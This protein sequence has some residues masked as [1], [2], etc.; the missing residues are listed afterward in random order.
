MTWWM[1]PSRNTN[2]G[3][4]TSTQPVQQ[5]QIRVE[6]PTAKKEGKEEVIIDNEEEE[7]KQGKDKGAT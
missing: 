2:E 4:A 5:P 6:T 1:P 3:A 7:D